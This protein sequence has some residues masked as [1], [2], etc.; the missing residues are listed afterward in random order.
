MVPIHHSPNKIFVG[1]TALSLALDV[2]DIRVQ[3]IRENIASQRLALHD[4]FV[5]LSEVLTGA[6][7]TSDTMP[8]T[9]VATMI[10]SITFTSG[11]T[12]PPIY[13]D[14]YEVAGTGDQTGRDGNANPF[15]N[16]DD[17]ELNIP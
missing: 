5:P 11:S 15:P 12:V 14:D 10:L 7:G 6:K 13:V 1:S 8:T 4:V 3:K 17:A 16:V 9:A 2:S